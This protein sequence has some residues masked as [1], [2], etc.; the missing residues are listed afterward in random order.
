MSSAQMVF[1]QTVFP[2]FWNP[3]SPSDGAARQGGEKVKTGGCFVF[4][5]SPVFSKEI[6]GIPQKKVGVLPRE[7]ESTGDVECGENGTDSR[8]KETER[9]LHENLPC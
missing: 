3:R 9:G 7:A 2:V 4:S 8:K 1:A 5:V 6:G